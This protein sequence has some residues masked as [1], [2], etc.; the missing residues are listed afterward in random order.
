VVFLEREG[1]TGLIQEVLP[2][3]SRLSRR[4][5]AGPH[6]HH[7]LE[8]VIVANVDQVVAVMSAAQPP[9]KWNLLDRYL[10]SAESLGLEAL[11]CLTKMDLAQADADLAAEIGLYRQIGYRVMETSVITGEGIADLRGALH[12]KLSVFIGKSGV[13]KS[14]LLN[15]IQPGLGL[16]IG[17]VSQLTG[18]G[19]HTTTELELFAVDN[20]GGK[21]ADTPGMREYGLWDV[22]GLD[23]AEFFPEMRPLLGTCRF[24]LDCTHQSEPGCAIRAAVAEGRIAARRYAS[25]LGLRSG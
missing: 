16:R 25:M 7:V 21:V 2:R 4:E 14:S 20:A 9:P 17:E 19:R 10:V 12:G 13:G 23:L 11:I 18:K 5:A 6:R 3:S 1:G 15:A 8:Q 22:E 24:K